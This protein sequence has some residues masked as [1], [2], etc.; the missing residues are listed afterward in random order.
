MG[1]EGEGGSGVVGEGKDDRTNLLVDRGGAGLGSLQTPHGRA[2][3]R[4]EICNTL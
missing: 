2:D 4:G 1:G 3:L